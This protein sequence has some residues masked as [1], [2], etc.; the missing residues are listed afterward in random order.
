MALSS[1][2]GMIGT[3]SSF[4]DAV[5]F[6]GPA[7]GLATTFTKVEIWLRRNVIVPSLK[8]RTAVP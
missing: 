1:H 5:C 8:M 7:T 6:L 2:E 3:F 4:S